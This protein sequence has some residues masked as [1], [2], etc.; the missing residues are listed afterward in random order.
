MSSD[1]DWI[2]KKFQG[3]RT[4]D[5]VLSAG[6]NIGDI[7]IFVGR[8]STI[9]HSCIL[10]WLDIESLKQGS[11]KTHPWYVNQETTTLSFLGL[12][13]GRKMDMATQQEQKGLILYEPTE[14]FVNA[15]I[16]YTRPLNR[17]NIS[18]SLVCQKM[19]E[20][21]QMHHLK[22]SYAYGIHH[23]ITVGLGIDV[24]GPHS[25]GGKIC[26]E[27][28]YLFLEHL[29]GY[30]GYNLGGDYEEYHLP[31]AKDYM[32]VPDFFFSEYNNHPVF[33]KEEYRVISKV[34]EEDITVLHPF[35]LVLVILILVLVL[36]FILI[37]NYCDSCTANPMGICPIGAKD[38]FDV[39]Y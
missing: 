1:E 4:G 18:D 34:A 6:K 31:D 36:V 11:I 16:V 21:I 10:V 29:C 8:Q 32:T 17:S 25:S 2:K 37:N 35:F 39:L 22:M 27:S 5:V 38:I 13:Q 14:L 19:E 20:Y 24:F 9:Q 26:S 23:I 3:L 12:A 30:P 33:D 28:V 15:P 7:M